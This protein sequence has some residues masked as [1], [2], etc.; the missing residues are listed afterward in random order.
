VFQNGSVYVDAQTG[1]VL[2]NGTVPQEITAEKAAQIASD[3]LQNKDILLVDQ[4]TFRGAPLNR[5]IFKNG[6]IV[7][8]DTTGQ[9]TYIL[10]SSPKL[11]DN[12]SFESG[13]SSGPSYSEHEEHEHEHEDD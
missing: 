13:G 1:E 12:Q 4:I 11:A 10:K 2:F 3:Y 8:L 5:V 7:Y 9:I 6:M